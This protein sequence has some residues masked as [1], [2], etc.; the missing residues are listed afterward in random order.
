MVFKLFRKTTSF[1]DC[2]TNSV[3]QKRVVSF[4]ISSVFFTDFMIFFLKNRRKSLPTISTNL[5]KNHAHILQFFTKFFGC[6]YI[7]FAPYPTL[8]LPLSHENKHK[9]ATFYFSFCLQK[10]KT[11]QLV[12]IY[13]YFL[14]VL[15]LG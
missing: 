5:I 14:W 10:S 9:S 4:N 2:S 3:S 7:S 1:S 8:Q 13:I 11:H 6:F 12:K 15:F